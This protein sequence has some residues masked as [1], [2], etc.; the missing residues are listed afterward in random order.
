MTE[1]NTS[2]RR[3]APGTAIRHALCLLAEKLLRWCVHPRLRAR[4]LR[5]L[6]ANIGENVRIYEV[7]LISLENGFRN[8]HVADN[9]HIGPRCILDLSAGVSIGE[10]SAISPGVMI[11]THADPGSSHG[12][13][14]SRLYPSIKGAVSIGTD[15]WIGAGAIVLAGIDIGDQVVVGA[16]SVVIRNLPAGHLC[17]GNPARVVKRIDAGRD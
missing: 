5:L 17:A 12:S 1:A 6:G 2:P 3:A 11:L 14:L 10:R 16:G 15:C 4:L 13:R 9:V 8:L 7:Q